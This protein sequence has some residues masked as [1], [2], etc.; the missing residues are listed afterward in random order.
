MDDRLD[1]IYRMRQSGL[2]LKQI[3]SH[4]GITAEA[5]RWHLLKHYGST[6]IHELLTVDELARLTGYSQGYILKLKRRGV[7]QPVK[8]G[9]KNRYWQPE[10][11]AT[12]IIYR[13][14]H[15]AQCRICQQ[16]LPAGRS[17][18]CSEACSTEGGKFKNRPQAV[19]DRQRERVARWERDHPEQAR[20]IHG[21]A[22]KKY[23]ATRH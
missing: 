17:V 11:I 3:G 8:V 14:R 15:L 4:F 22:A 23:R 20:K 2:T 1:T 10:T 12:I 5:V 7:I 9:R 6:E 13:D 16:P 21:R 18:F 19:K